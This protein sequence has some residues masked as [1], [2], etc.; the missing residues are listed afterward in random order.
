MNWR[1]MLPK[2][3]PLHREPEPE[4]K[5][6]FCEAATAGGGSRW[7]IR[8][9]TRRGKMLGGGADTPALCGRQVSWDV[10]P[11]V[12]ERQLQGACPICARIYRDKT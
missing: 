7:H 8:E 3:H 6:A 10:R 9:L 12:N 2:F 11:D 5:F 4:Q 1:E